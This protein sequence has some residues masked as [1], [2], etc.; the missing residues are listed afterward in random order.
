MHTV[1]FSLERRADVRG[2]ATTRSPHRLGTAG[3]SLPQQQRDRPSSAGTGS[4]QRTQSVQLSVFARAHEISPT[5]VSPGHRRMMA[6]PHPA[7]QTT[8]SSSPNWSSGSRSDWDRCRGRGAP[9]EA[10][11]PRGAWRRRTARSGGRAA[12]RWRGRGGVVGA[13]LRYQPTRI[14]A[15]REGGRARWRGAAAGT[16][17]ETMAPQP[18]SS[19]GITQ[20]KSSSCR[21]LRDLRIC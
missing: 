5:S 19:P 14:G 2:W 17:S 4:P 18:Q 15:E 20:A 9:R 7:G 21:K 1:E 10:E 11:A 6:R 12:G 13:G 3:T 8:S 16:F